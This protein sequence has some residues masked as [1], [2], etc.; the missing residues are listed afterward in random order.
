EQFRIIEPAL[1][2]EKPTAPNRGQL[3]VLG[4]LLALA[5][6]VGGVVAAEHLDT[7]FH[8]C[9]DLRLH[10]RVPVLA[11]IPRVATPPDRQE[12]PRRLPLPTPA[13][14]RAGRP[15]PATPGG[16]RTRP[17]GCACRW[18]RPTC[19]GPAS[20]RSSACLRG[21]PAWPRRSR[22]ARGGSTS[23]A[24]RSRDSTCGC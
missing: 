6:A 2:S 11:S 24:C 3:L 23:C 16:P 20:P 4:I 15:R 7:S 9:E 12:R 5:L 10:S 8:T 18:W 13:A 19:A 21:G 17:P 1:I 22:T 14:A